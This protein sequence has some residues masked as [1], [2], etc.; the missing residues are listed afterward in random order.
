[1]RAIPLTQGKEVIVDKELFDELNQ[2]KWYYH[3][4]Y[5]ARTERIGG[6]RITLYMH[7]FIMRPP[8]GFVVDHIDG[9]K[10]KNTRDNLRICTRAQNNMNMRN[11]LSRKSSELRSK[12]KGVYKSKGERKW[13][14]QIRKNGRQIHIGYFWDEVEAA[15]AY[16]EKA[17][18]LFGE[19]A[20]P[21][22][23]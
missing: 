1:V 22:F 4:G 21:N 9:N 2:C 12:Y 11:T 7:R 16:D 8:K 6:K 14:A 3:K 10:L 19:F 18:E 13:S 23:S 20:S 17:R 5:A 15:L